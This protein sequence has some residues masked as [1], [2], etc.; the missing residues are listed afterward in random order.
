MRFLGM[1]HVYVAL[2]CSCFWSCNAVDDRRNLFFLGVRSSGHLLK[3]KPKFSD[4]PLP[5]HEPLEGNLL[6]NMGKEDGDM[7]KEHGTVTN[8]SDNKPKDE[9]TTMMNALSPESV[10]A[11]PEETTRRALEQLSMAF[12]GEALNGYSDV[13]LKNIT[14]DFDAGHMQAIAGVYGEVLPQ[15][16]IHMLALALQ[17]NPNL[18]DSDGTLK[19]GH[20]YDLGS[21]FGKAV[22]LASL[23]GFEG[24]GIELSSHRFGSACETLERLQKP[25]KPDGATPDANPDFIGHS[26][27]ECGSDGHGKAKFSKGSFLDDKAD[28]SDADLVFTDSVYWTPEQMKTLGEKASKMKSGSIIVSYRPLPGNNL[29]SLG[30]VDLP[31]SWLNGPREG[32]SFQ[33]QQVK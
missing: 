28:I 33:V 30:K 21:G 3:E 5:N 8:S 10:V 19:P 27:S 24:D 4:T 23:L 16:V 22:M 18:H 13:S 17:K 32:V 20:F 11:F 14:Q 2:V 1:I 12:D 26:R 31:V 15:A 7:G 29:A 25:P 9:V 6:M